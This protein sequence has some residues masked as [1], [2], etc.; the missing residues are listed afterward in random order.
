MTPEH[1]K[2][3][4]NAGLISGYHLL[5]GKEELL[6]EEDEVVVFRDYFVVGLVIP[7]HQ[8]VLAVLDRYHIQL[9]KL[10]PTAL[11]HLSKFL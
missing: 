3:L 9:H 10:T 2:E 5:V 4:V 8:F 1:L 11:A 7:F 6:P